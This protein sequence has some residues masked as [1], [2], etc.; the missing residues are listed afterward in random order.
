MSPAP[1]CETH[2]QAPTVLCGV[3]VATPEARGPALHDG[4]PPSAS[5]PDLEAS[6]VTSSATVGLVRPQPH[7]RAREGVGTLRDPIRRWFWLSARSARGH[8]VNWLVGAVIRESFDRRLATVDL[9]IRPV[10]LLAHERRIERCTLVLDVDERRNE[11]NLHGCCVGLEPRGDLLGEGL[12]QAA[13]DGLLLCGETAP[14]PVGDGSQSRLDA[15]EIV[16]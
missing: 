6:T 13:H 14:S 5:P 11:M 15:D 3:A 1:R 7:R 10:Q 2:D 12:Q 8:V 16:G 4:R 9:V